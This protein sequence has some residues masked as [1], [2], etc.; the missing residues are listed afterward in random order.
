[1]AVIHNPQSVPALGMP[2]AAWLFQVKKLG[3]LAIAMDSTGKNIF[4]SKVDIAL[5]RIYYNL[6]INQ[7][8]KY[9]S[10]P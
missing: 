2:S 1:M 9:I 5:K 10:G 3:T 8:H 4:R 6:G 7:E